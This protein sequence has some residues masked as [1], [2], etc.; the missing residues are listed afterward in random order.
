MNFI[1]VSAVMMTEKYHHRRMSIA[2]FAH[3]NTSE[4]HCNDDSK[5]Q[6]VIIDESNVTSAI[7]TLQ[8]SRES[9]ALIK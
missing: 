9:F 2:Q 4:N 6:Y 8:H 1:S 5:N 3:Y 7:F